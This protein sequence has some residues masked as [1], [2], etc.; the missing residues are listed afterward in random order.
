METSKSFAKAAMARF[1][2]PTAA[3][4]TFTDASEAEAYIRTVGHRVVVKASGLAAG[5]G[6]RCGST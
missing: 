1:G 5:K 3:G 4:R 2:V 6:A